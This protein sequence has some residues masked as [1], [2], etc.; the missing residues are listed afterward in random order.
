MAS[1]RTSY[2][3]VNRNF[4]E[5]FP[6]DSQRHGLLKVIL[7]EK[8]LMGETFFLFLINCKKLGLLKSFA[9]LIKNGSNNVYDT[10]LCLLIGARQFNRRRLTT[11]SNCRNVFQISLQ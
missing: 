8:L 1:A 3:L 2:P 6:C 4:A 11:L 10:F 9:E 7:K 5:I